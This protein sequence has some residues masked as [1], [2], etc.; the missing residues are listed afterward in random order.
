MAATTTTYKVLLVGDG[1]V[2]KSAFLSKMKNN[3]FP[4]QYIATMGAEVHPI[5]IGDRVYKIWD[6]AGQEKL[7]GLRQGYYIEAD[8][9]I[10][11][12]SCDSVLTYR[13]LPNWV[14]DVQRVVSNIP[15]IIVNSLLHGVLGAKKKNGKKGETT[16]KVTTKWNIVYFF[17]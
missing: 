6:T 3:T 17:L 1:G 8:A 5:V 12:Y 16:K 7:S 10:F 11:M 15:Y 14:R 4:K 13:N 9:V 2:G